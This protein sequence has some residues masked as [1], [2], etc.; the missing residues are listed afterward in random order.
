MKRHIVFVLLLIIIFAAVFGAYWAIRADISGGMKKDVLART[1]KYEKSVLAGLKAL[2]SELYAHGESIRLK[3]EVIRYL[4]YWKRGYQVPEPFKKELDDY[5]K[6]LNLGFLNIICDYGKQFVFTDSGENADALNMGKYSEAL[7]N[8]FSIDAKTRGGALLVTVYQKIKFEE[9]VIGLTQYGRRMEQDFFIKAAGD[10]PVQFTLFKGSSVI[11][12]NLREK[13]GDMPQTRKKTGFSG[14]RYY[15]TV[16]LEAVYPGSELLLVI[17]ERM[18][19][20]VKNIS[21]IPY[22]LFILA[23]V[24]I[25]SVLSAYVIIFSQDRLKLYRLEKAMERI[26]KGNLLTR[27]P[28]SGI[29]IYRVF[30]SMTENINNLF[31]GLKKS[32]RTA[33][34]R[35]AGKWISAILESEACA[36]ALS[37]FRMKYGIMAAEEGQNI[38]LVDVHAVAR[39]IVNRTGEEPGKKITLSAPAGSV[40]IK[41]NRQ[42]IEDFLGYMVFE[43]AKISGGTAHMDIRQADGLV[44]IGIGSFREGMKKEDIP[45]SPDLR[46][47]EKSALYP[48]MKLYLESL[49]GDLEIY[50]DAAGRFIR[51]RLKP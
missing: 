2:N 27:L 1:D 47:G 23:L 49:G 9:E 20:P 13:F 51:I 18:N 39:G 7:K 22:Y 41:A 19:L 4:V 31:S 33:A 46:E 36:P 16:N 50:G 10:Y 44:K 29:N 12:S 35:E 42:A 24:I 5:R 40:G 21:H 34:Y 32:E 38:E 30:N 26:G 37:E 48:L 15:S 45:A 43:T 28:E 25:F 17:S 11:M 6:S 8:G 3:N 14:N